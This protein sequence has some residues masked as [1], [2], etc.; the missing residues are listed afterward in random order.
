LMNPTTI[1]ADGS[2]DGTLGLMPVKI[3]RQCPY[4]QHPHRLAR[5]Q[6]RVLSVIKFICR[7]LVVHKQTAQFNPI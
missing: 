5:V 4:T 7:I 2:A 1:N 3:I 6:S